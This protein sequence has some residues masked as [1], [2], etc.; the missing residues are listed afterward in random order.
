MVADEHNEPDL[1][2]LV[3][4][5]DCRLLGI[6]NRS[7]ITNK[8]DVP[9]SEISKVLK[10]IRKRT[11]EYHALVLDRGMMWVGVPG[12]CKVGQDIIFNKMCI[13]YKDS[14]K[15]SE[16]GLLLRYP[17]YLGEGT[18]LDD[19]HQEFLIRRPHLNFVQYKKNPNPELR[20]DNT[21]NIVLSIFPVSIA[22]GLSAEYDCSKPK[23]EGEGRIS[24]YRLPTVTAYTLKK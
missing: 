3:L 6:T 13:S 24:M 9:T 22:V 1:E 8:V 12:F 7:Q 18:E 20:D 21:A 23:S 5:G 14:D 17:H 16:R 19:Y 11:G 15:A 2:G 10:S 4:M